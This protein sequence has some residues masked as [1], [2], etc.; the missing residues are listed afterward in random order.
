M[1]QTEIQNRLA[2]QNLINAYCYELGVGRYIE[3]SEQNE[4][5]LNFSQRQ[6]LLEVPLLPTSMLLRVPI[7]KVSQL[8]NV[9]FSEEPTVFLNGQSCDYTASTVATLVLQSIAYYQLSSNT[10]STTDKSHEVLGRWLQS[11]EGLGKILTHRLDNIDDIVSAELNFV[12]TE[13]NLIYGH[14]MHPTPKG[15]DGFYAQEW[16]QYAPETQSK[17][18]LNYWLVQSDYVTGNWVDGEDIYQELLTKL[19]PYLTDYQQKML[20]Q[21]TDYRLLP[22]HPWQARFLQQQPWYETLFQQQKI[23]PL[24]AMG[25]YLSPTTSVR[26]LASFDA[27]WMF[28]LSLSVAITNSV[29]INLAKEC[30]RG[31]YA[32][33]IWRSEFG[34]RLKQ[35]YPTL[36]VINDPAWLALTIDGE[37]INETICIL[38]DNPFDPSIQVSNLASLCQDHPTRCTNRIKTL[39]QAIK[40]NTA[41]DNTVIANDWFDSYLKVGFEPLVSLYYEHGLGFE[42]HQQNSLLELKDYYPS[43]LW[44]RDNQGFGYIAEYAGSLID[45]I[46]ALMD[47][48]ECVVPEFFANERFAYYIIANHLFGL[49]TAIARTGWASE[50]QL[51][52]QLVNRLMALE[53]RYPHRELFELLLRQDTLPFKGNLLTRMQGLDELTAPVETQSVYVNVPNPLQPIYSR[54]L[55]NG[56]HCA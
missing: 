5:C 39:F 53:Q 10:Q 55:N 11:Y 2:L 24:G 13:Q 36:S 15:R 8:G 46:P 28:K 48:A 22:L 37:V 26:T 17:F 14:T 56:V 4:A 6:P 40:A 1:L 30:Q 21:H 27:P 9:R 31:Y 23:Y 50:E 29:R 35:Q 41:Q 19:T 52:T 45:E 51:L 7:D 25:W 3:V 32:C 54:Q 20:Q 38:R 16:E 12:E 34:K 49:I 43:R 47:E 44:V 33:Q 42:A 18:Q